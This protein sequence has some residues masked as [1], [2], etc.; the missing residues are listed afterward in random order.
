MNGVKINNNLDGLLTL[1][2]TYK[3]ICEQHEVEEI[4]F[5]TASTVI[6]QSFQ[7][8]RELF[9]F[10]ANREASIYGGFYSVKRTVIERVIEFLKSKNYYDMFGR[11]ANESFLFLANLVTNL[12]EKTISQMV[13]ENGKSA[14]GCFFNSLS[15]GNP[16][17]L[18]TVI[19]FVE[20]SSLEFLAPYIEA[21]LSIEEALKRAMRIT[22]KTWKNCIKY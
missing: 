13:T 20:C 14:L 5:S 7:N 16:Q 3:V 4:I 1:L 18:Q 8:L 12:N 17:P 21:R 6:R 2:F 11:T 15:F 10:M 22:L 9:I 19:L